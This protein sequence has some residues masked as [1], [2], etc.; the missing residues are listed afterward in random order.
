MGED[1][2]EFSGCKEKWIVYNMAFYERLRFLLG[3][4]AKKQEFIHCG[5]PKEK[6]YGTQEECHMRK[7]K[8]KKFVA[9]MGEL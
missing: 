9:K 7:L 8:K 3:F 4:T 6:C 1:L 5:N 2:K